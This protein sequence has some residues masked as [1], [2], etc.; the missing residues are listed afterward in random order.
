MF[1]TG[2]AAE[3]LMARLPEGTRADY[4][5]PE[6]LIALM[7]AKDAAAVRGDDLLQGVAAVDDCFEL[8]GFNQL[9][10]EQHILAALGRGAGAYFLPTSK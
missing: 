3:A 4:G 5:S 9:F 2:L 6:K 7:L 10:E 8:S 1:G